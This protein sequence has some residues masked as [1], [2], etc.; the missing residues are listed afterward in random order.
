M[1]YANPTKHLGRAADL[2]PW[3]LNH[4]VVVEIERDRFEKCWGVFVLGERVRTHIHTHTQAEG[5]TEGE[6]ES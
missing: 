5:E 2:H 1:C 4:A 3:V 6:K